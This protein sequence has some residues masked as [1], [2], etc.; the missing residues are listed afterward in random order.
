MALPRLN[1]QHDILGPEQDGGKFEI[2][3]YFQLYFIEKIVFWFKQFI[4]LWS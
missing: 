1:E 4:P 3:N 2:E